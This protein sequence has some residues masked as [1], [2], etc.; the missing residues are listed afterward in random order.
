[1]PLSQLADEI[2]RL[3]HAGRTTPVLV[4]PDYLSLR[5]V[6]FAELVD[7]LAQRTDRAVRIDWCVSGQTGLAALLRRP[8]AR[9]QADS[10]NRLLRTRSRRASIQITASITRPGNADHLVVGLCDQNGDLSPWTTPIELG[11][12]P[13]RLGDLQLTS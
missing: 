5:R 13:A 11:S 4:T 1:M 3:S 7:A 8:F 10:I 2:T 12:C 6:F 9:W